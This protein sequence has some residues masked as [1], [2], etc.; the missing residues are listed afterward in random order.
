MTTLKLTKKAVDASK[1]QASRYTINDIEL[2]GFQCR[3]SPS[4]SKIYYLYY[5]TQDGRERRPKIGVHGVIA[6]EKARGIAKQWM[7]LVAEGKDPSQVRQEKRGGSTIK[8]FAA[9]YLSV[10]AETHKKQSST[11]GDRRNI[12]KHIIPAIGTLKI[13][14]ISRRDIIKL[15]QSMR[16]VPYAANRVLALLSKMFNLAELWEIRKQGSNPC[17]HVSKYKES[18][19]ER[20]LSLDELSYISVALVEAENNKTESA[21]AI[22]AI[23]LLIFTGCRRD[24]IL[25]LGWIDVDMENACLNLPDSKTGKKKIYLTAP[26]MAI[27]S[28]LPKLD[29]NPWVVTGTKSGH[30]LVNLFKVWKRIKAAATIKIWKDQEHLSVIFKGTPEYQNCSV[31]EIVEECQKLDISPIGGVLDVR[32]HDLRHTFASFAVGT[33]LSL[34]MTGKL[35]GH[36]QVQT[37]ARY[38]HLAEDP[39]RQ[40]AETTAS[41]I[42]AAMMQSKKS[43]VVKL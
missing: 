36:T 28:E 7:G 32:L 33:G 31:E 23:R 18:K 6:T 42:N 30:H 9:H 3:V 19:R 27:L 41:N 8:E 14:E 21:T 15:H 10:Y 11:D 29:G 26:A 25:K 24:E 2:K 5:R 16:M 37:T 4:G 17:A 1:P 43:N 39:V 12:N 34:H 35:L 22:A 13:S 20:Y 40:A 38:A